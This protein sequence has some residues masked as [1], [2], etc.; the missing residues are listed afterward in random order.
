MEGGQAG[1]E[2]VDQR[3]GEDAVVE[4]IPLLETPHLHQVFQDRPVATEPRLVR[5]AGDRDQAQV[6]LGGEAVVEA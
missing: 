5:G 3:R 1:R 4:P 6:K 2:A